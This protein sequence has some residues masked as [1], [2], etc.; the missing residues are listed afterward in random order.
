MIVPG[1]PLLFS[2][3]PTDQLKNAH[4]GEVPRKQN[5]ADVHSVVDRIEARERRAHLVRV[6]DDPDSQV[7]R[8]G[9]HP[10]RGRGPSEIGHG[11]DN[12]GHEHD[13][14][15]LDRSGKQIE[16]Q[17]NQK[18]VGKVTNRSTPRN[19]GSRPGMCHLPMKA[20]S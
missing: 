10:F 1:S 11:A 12:Q 5:G 13:A 4:P 17:G 20:D 7:R 18:P 15:E 8:T 9:D 3:P 16:E 14:C 2:P 19:V 6:D